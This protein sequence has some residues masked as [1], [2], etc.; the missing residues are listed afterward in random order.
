M[1][2]FLTIVL[3]FLV[4]CSSVTKKNNFNFSND[5]SF[6]EFIISLEDYAK[7]TSYPNIDD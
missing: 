4:S 1:I 3:F 2:R 5:M 6:N 7:N